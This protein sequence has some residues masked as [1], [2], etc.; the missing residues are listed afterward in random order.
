MRV[1]DLQEELAKFDPDLEL[2]VYTEDESML[3]AGHLFRLLDVEYV[4][5]TEG[6]LGRGEDGITSMRFVK[7]DESRVVVTLGAT[8]SF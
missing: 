4:E 6:E 7:S 8:G 1:G 2:L 5:K 3:S